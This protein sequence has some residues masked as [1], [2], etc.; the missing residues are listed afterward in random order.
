[1]DELVWPPGSLATPPATSGASH[2]SSPSKAGFHELKSIV[3]TSDEKSEDIASDNDND[4][5][6]DESDRS[7]R[8]SYNLSVLIGDAHSLI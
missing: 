5:S 6:D 7:T 1:M 2:Q 4:S 3:S 8:T